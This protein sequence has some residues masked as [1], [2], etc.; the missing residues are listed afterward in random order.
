MDDHQRNPERRKY[1]IVFDAEQI[2]AGDVSNFREQFNPFRLTGEELRLLFGSVSL[3]LAWGESGGEAVFI[4]ECRRFIRLLH[5]PWLGFFLAEEAPVDLLAPL[6]PLPF[7]GLALCLS[8]L[9]LWSDDQSGRTKVQAN[10]QQVVALETELIFG[11]RHL[12]RRAG[13]SSRRIALR[14]LEIRSQTSVLITEAASPG[15]GGE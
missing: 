7:L 2:L 3:Q 6:G 8:D 5:C 1:H 10:R 14:E 9:C 13:L 4:P 15:P 12:G 11:L